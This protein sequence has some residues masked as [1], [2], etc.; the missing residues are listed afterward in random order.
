MTRAAGWAAGGAR[1]RSALHTCAANC[2]LP[3]GSA[4]TP[5]CHTNPVLASCLPPQEARGGAFGALRRRA[6]LS[7]A[8]AR[9]DTA[10]D[11]ISR[12]RQPAGPQDSTRKQAAP[13]DACGRG[14]W[15]TGRASG[16]CGAGGKLS[17]SKPTPRMRP[18]KHLPK[19]KDGERVSRV[20][21]S[22]AQVKRGSD[23]RVIG[24]SA[25]DGGRW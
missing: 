18:T 4:H 16:N 24:T 17:A 5:D 23:G 9:G 19:G 20:E 8:A 12:A 22:R 10:L 21:R 1:G 7:A 14:G 25:T 13:W 11:A 3:P 2:K 6:G 15:G